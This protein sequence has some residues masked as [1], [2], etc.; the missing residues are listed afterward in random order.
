[1][2]TEYAFIPLCKVMLSMDEVNE[3]LSILIIAR[4]KVS[5]ELREEYDNLSTTEKERTKEEFEAKEGAFQKKWV[6][7]L[8]KIKY[9]ME[10]TIKDGLK[11]GQ[12]K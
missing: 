5:F 12:I 3:L 4:D 2:E 9:R 7:P 11:Y 1:M 10:E 6:E 8:L